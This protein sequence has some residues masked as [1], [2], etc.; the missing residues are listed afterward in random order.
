MRRL[1]PQHPALGGGFR[2]DHPPGAGGQTVF[3]QGALGGGGYSCE[4]SMSDDGLTM[5]TRADTY[6]VNIF[7]RSTQIVGADFQRQKIQRNDIGGR[8]ARLTRSQL[9]QE[10]RI[11]FMSVRLVLKRG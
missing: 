5:I 2:T 11:E 9:L 10:I 3:T 8:E 4:L 7:N 1:A 6:Q